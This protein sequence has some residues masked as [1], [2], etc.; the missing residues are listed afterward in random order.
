MSGIPEVIVSVAGKLIEPRYVFV[1]DRFANDVVKDPDNFGFKM[2]M[3]Q[4]IVFENG[5]MAQIRIYMETHYGSL[6]SATAVIFLMIGQDDLSKD[7]ETAIA[8][9]LSALVESYF[10]PRGPR[11]IPGED[12]EGV[13]LA[14]EGLVARALVL[15]PGAIIVSSN[16]APRRSSEGFAVQHALYVANRVQRQGTRHHHFSMLRIFYGRRRTSVKGE[17]LGGNLPILEDCFNSDGIR[18]SLA[19]MCGV[20]VRTYSFI[21]AILQDDPVLEQDPTMIDGLVMK[22]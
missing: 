22:F 15:F 1:M 17:R 9:P 5:T 4:L 3:D 11:Q 16:P 20:F 2:D 21:G 12:K 13:R 19:A 10:D 8:I 6:T 18:L 14:Y 7:V